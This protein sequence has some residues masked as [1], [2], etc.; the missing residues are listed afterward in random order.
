MQDQ[1]QTED[2]D[3]CAF[4]TEELGVE[5]GEIFMDID[6]VPIASASLSQVY[7]ATLKENTQKIVIKA[8]RK[9]ERE[10]IEVDVMLIKDLD[11]RLEDYNS[12]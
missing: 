4:I 11:N 5:P 8:K 9:G 7:T 2:I 6:T 3:I 1:V 12:V 10:S